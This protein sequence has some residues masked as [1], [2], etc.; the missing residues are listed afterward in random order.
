MRVVGFLHFL[1]V[2]NG[3][4]AQNRFKSIGLNLFGTHPFVRLIYYMKFLKKLSMKDL[5][6]KKACEGPISIGSLTL[7]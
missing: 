1:S 4:I 6:I 3:I 7:E 5:E 2:E